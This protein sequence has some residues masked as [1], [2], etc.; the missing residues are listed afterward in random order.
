MFVCLFGYYQSCSSLP[1]F[2]ICLIESRL[3]VKYDLH[4][5]FA[6]IGQFVAML[7]LNMESK[8]VA[9]SPNSAYQPVAKKIEI[10]KKN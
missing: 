3:D 5:T 6:Y 9:N 2:D 1:G 10:E 7:Y 8:F 4:L